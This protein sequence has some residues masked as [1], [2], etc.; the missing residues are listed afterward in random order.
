VPRKWGAWIEAVNFCSEHFETVKSVVTKFPSES[1]LLVHESQ[2]AFSNLK[3]VCS[4][5][6]I[7]S[8]F[9]WLPEIIKRLETQGLSLQES[10]D[11]MKNASEKA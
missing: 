11:I 8:N 2:S 7:Q 6:Y 4:V 3:V 10:M 5:A 9:G 1:A